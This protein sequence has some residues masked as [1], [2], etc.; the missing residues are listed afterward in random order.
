ML[1][2]KDSKPMISNRGNAENL[3]ISAAHYRHDYDSLLVKR[4]NVLRLKKNKIAG[5]SMI[6]D[7]TV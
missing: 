4:N 2:K 1:L 3:G 7:G 6:C 5:F